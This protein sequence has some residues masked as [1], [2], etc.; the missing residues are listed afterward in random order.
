[1]L[2]REIKN[3]F[4]TELDVLY[5]KEEVNSFFYLLIEHY[6]DLERFVLAIQPELVI[7]KEQETIIFNALSKLKL[8]KPIQH[9]IGTAYFMDLDFKVNKNVLIP[10]PETEELVRWILDDF[11]TAAKTLTILDMGTGSGCIPISLDKN[12]TDA[13]VFGLDISSDALEVAKENNGLLNASVEFI[14]ADI[15][16]LKNGTS[17]K[18]LNQK[19]DI[20]ISNPPYVRELEKAEMKKN[21]IDH[22]P[23]LALFVPDNDPLKFYNV[24]VNFAADHLNKNGC[25]YLEINQ[26]LGEETKQLLLDSNFK[27]IEL[28]KDMF[29]NDR[30]IKGTKK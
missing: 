27:T 4:H 26:Y 11:K 6:F 28:R 24:V 7:D 16:S 23:S 14:Q 12:L 30:M 19:F 25:L 20:I 21:V 15:F 2:L 8:E 18:E 1:M 13:K 9:I 10:R 17:V 5:G 3:I 29:G 22:E